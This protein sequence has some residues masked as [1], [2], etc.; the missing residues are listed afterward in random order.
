MTEI[1]P[2][3][4]AQPAGLSQRYGIG[5]DRHRLEPGEGLILAGVQ[6][7]CELRAVAHS[8]GD[9]VLHAVAD[10]ILGAAGG[11]DIGDLFADDDPQWKDLDSSIIVARAMPMVC[12][13]GLETG[14]GGCR[15]SSRATQTG[16]PSGRDESIPGSTA[17]DPGGLCRA[18]GEDR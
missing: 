6:I 15:H 12:C 7:P 5:T 17:F 3:S 18:Q 13:K 4:S 14:S 11:T 1:D 2:S 16:G 10:A 8:D 9:A